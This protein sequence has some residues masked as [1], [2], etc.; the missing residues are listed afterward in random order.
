HLDSR[1]GRL[2]QAGSLTGPLHDLAAAT[3]G[4]KTYAFGG[5]ASTTVDTVQ[6]LSPGGS[7]QQVGHLPAALSDLSATSVAGRIYVLGG[8]DG[9]AASASVFQ[10]VDG[11]TFTRVARM[12]TPVRYTAIATVGDKIYAFGGELA[13]GQDTNEIQEYDIGT[14]RA[15][16]AGHL[17]QPVS[18]AAA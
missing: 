9:W 4:G 18:H 2:S 16:V 15:V 7:A 14:E 11:R 12:P 17:A 5:G 13:N 6:A 8:F 10:T 3:L 1:T